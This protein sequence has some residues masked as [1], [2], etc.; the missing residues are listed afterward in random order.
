VIPQGSAVINT[1]YFDSLVDR[2]NSAVD[3]SDLQD[4]VDDAFGSLSAHKAAVMAQIEALA[5]FLALLNPPTIDPSKIVTWITSL[6]TTQIAPQVQ[7]YT[8]YATEI[9]ML[10]SK[11][12]E[13]TSAVSAA[14]QRLKDKAATI[15][16][17]L[18][19]ISIPSF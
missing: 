5:P 2:L 13:L 15:G 3:I 16:G 1:A 4:T 19:S 18:P 8:Q 17:T 6:I 9:A 12:G 14:E 7:V 11:V 10:T